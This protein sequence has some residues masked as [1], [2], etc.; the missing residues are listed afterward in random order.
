MTTKET[1]M[2]SIEMANHREGL[3]LGSFIKRL[4]GM[5]VMVVGLVF[6][7]TG[8]SLLCP[9]I[10]VAQDGVGAT[11]GG[12][13]SEGESALFYYAKALG[14]VFGPAFLLLSFYF[15][16]LLVMC[17]LQ[18][19][20]AVVLPED[21]REEFESHLDAKEYQQAYELVKEDDSYFG[22]VMA[23]GM[24]RIQSGYSVAVDA[25]RETEGE[26][27]MLLEHKV[28][29]V[30]LVGAIAPMLG[31]LGTVSGMVGSFQ[32]IAQSATAPKPA[33]LAGGI[34]QA[35]VT[36]LI[37]LMIAIPA[38]AAFSMLKNW[39][40]VINAEIDSESLRLMSRFQGVGKK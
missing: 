13:D 30:S 35:L 5:M 19:R 9:D 8:P 3:K 22:R 10:A 32:V 16:S 18:I 34:S 38:T 20:R 36:T 11:D 39:L 15:V 14:W 37:G 21:L 6:V 27:A 7:V 40:Q 17:L 4:L 26:Q 31:L 1:S 33:E 29:Y 24:A 12:E 25:M 23:A 2:R 28:S